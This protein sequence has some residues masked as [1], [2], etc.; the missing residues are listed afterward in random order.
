M[1]EY[2]RTL[3]QN[4]EKTALIPTMGALHRGHLSLITEARNYASR[5][6][7]SIYV[8]PTQ[9]APHEDFAT[10]PRPL[11]DDL[12]LLASHEVDAVFT[13]SSEE[14]YPA[15]FQTTVRNTNLSSSLCGIK[16]P[17]FFQGVCTVVLKLLNIVNPHYVIFGRKDFQQLRVIEQMVRDLHLRTRV[18]A[19]P[20]VREADGLALSSRNAYLQPQQR[21]EALAL[22]QGL[23]ATARLYQE[24][25]RSPGALVSTAQRI[26]EQRGQLVVEYLSVC[27]RDNLEAFAGL[28]T[29]PAILLAAVQLGQVRLIDN[30]DLG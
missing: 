1:S 7:V 25:E 4:H 27:R 15:D 26:I 5:V 9:F 8:N 14:L 20:L 18:L 6:L 19:A 16:R 24:G 11:T 28:I 22:S 17:H 13:P 29:A 12:A 21:E 10:Y 30:I 23:F 3:A 2:S